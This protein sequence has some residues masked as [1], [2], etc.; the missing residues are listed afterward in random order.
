MSFFHELGL[1]KPILRA[2]DTQGYDTP[3][4]I[5]R[6]AIPPLLK[7][8]D[9]MGIAQTGT[10]KTAAFSLP[11]IHNLTKDGFTPRQP[12]SCRMLVLSPTRELAAQIA[13]SMKG[14]A[15]GSGLKVNVVFGGK[16]IGAQAKG[17]VGGCD[18]LV[19]TPGR[20][21][22][23]IDRRA[24]TLK[25]V[26]IFVLDEADQMMD[27][28]FIKP[29]QQI[30][31]MLPQDRQSLFFSATM[32]KA[33]ADLGKQFISDPVRVEV[34]PQASTA[35]RIDQRVTFVDQREKQALLTM[36]LG[37]MFE[38]GEMDRALV[39]TRTK[40]GADRV[41]RHLIGA[42]IDAAAIHG[43][44]SQGQ[45]TAAL[46]G[47]RDG[48]VR[49]LVATDIAARGIDVPGVSHVFNFEL[50]NVPEQY[51]HRIGRTARAGREG[52]AI[53]F[54]APDEKAYL[55]DI[56]RLTGVRIDK[57]DL[58]ENFNN[59]AAALPKPAG[60]T[61]GKGKWTP[62]GEDA[63]SDGVNSRPPHHR[64]GPSKPK[65]GIKRRGNTGPHRGRDERTGSD[66]G[67]PRR[68]DHGA[69]PARK[70]HRKGGGQKVASGQAPRGG[71]GPGDQRRGPHRS[72]GRPGNR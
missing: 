21:L 4:P 55:R 49:I 1:A 26:E 17:L 53:S 47:F 41:V 2:L 51:V 44:K 42:G 34:T 5:Q 54:C 68:D 7:G 8:R 15:Q 25:N 57:A 23:L 72:G 65:H 67:A 13:S 9:L 37:A 31:R 20:L 61:A 71:K 36:R 14:Y 32:P 69:R 62:M 22:D 58:P 50:P 48:A 35:E 12:A 6:E 70:P 60:R 39:F 3:T 64:R 46:N 43:N 29:L 30:A 16:P 11:S 28:G 33:I 38:S 10:G 66:D 63:S 59:R 27:L 40:H 19:A 45:R 52:V 18:I 56:E 24:L